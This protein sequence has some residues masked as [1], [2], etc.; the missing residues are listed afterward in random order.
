MNDSGADEVL[1]GIGSA[2]LADCLKRMG[3][4]PNTGILV[5]IDVRR[6]RYKCTREVSSH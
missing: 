3:A 5:K 1:K 2:S 4:Q 6:R